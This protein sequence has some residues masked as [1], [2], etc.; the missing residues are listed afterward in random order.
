VGDG[1]VRDDWHN[2]V[3]FAYGDDGFDAAK[4]KGREVLEGT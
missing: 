1:S 2:V 3:Q 4:K